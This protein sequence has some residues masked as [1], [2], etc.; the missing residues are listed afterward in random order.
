MKFYRNQRKIAAAFVDFHRSARKIRDRVRI[1][2]ARDIHPKRT[3]MV[4]AIILILNA[5]CH[6]RAIH[7]AVDNVNIGNLAM[8]IRGDGE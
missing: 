2:A 6:F 8:Q 1:I 7:A 3:Q 5:N 4:V